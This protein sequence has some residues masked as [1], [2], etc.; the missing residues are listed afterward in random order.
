MPETI[1]FEYKIIE[2]EYQE[3]DNEKELE[4]LNYLGSDGW[5]LVTVTEIEKPGWRGLP[6]KRHKY[7]FKRPIK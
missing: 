7:F 2:Y 6:T 4:E 1:E 5:E 3:K